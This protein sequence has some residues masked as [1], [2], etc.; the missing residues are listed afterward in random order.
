MG[1]FIFVYLLLF[2]P[3]FIDSYY[4]MGAYMNKPPETPT[5]ATEFELTISFI[6]VAVIIGSFQLIANIF[7]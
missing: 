5:P 2:K 1:S 6:G 3:N 4:Q 7:F